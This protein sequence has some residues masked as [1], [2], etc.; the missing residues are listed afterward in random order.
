[1]SEIEL[2][3]PAPRYHA[4]LLR[5]WRPDRDA[6]AWQASLQDPKTG[7]RIGFSDLE[8]LFAYLIRLAEAHEP[9]P[10]DPRST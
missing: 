2:H 6:L 7:E 1:M 8:D 10:A 5:M 3:S 9:P 4:Y